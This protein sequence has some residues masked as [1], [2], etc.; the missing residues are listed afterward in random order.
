MSSATKERFWLVGAG[1]VASPLALWGISKERWGCRTMTETQ[2]RGAESVRDPAVK[3]ALKM[4]DMVLVDGSSVDGFDVFEVAQET[5]LIKE[6]EGGY[7]PD[8]HGE[9][10]AEPGDS[11]Y[12]IQNESLLREPAND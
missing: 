11:W 8:V 3:F 2:K 4:M 5:G 9:A 1:G 6:V 7:N 12:M 10:D